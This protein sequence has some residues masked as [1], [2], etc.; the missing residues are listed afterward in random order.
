M[1][2]N[3]VLAGVVIC[4]GSLMSTAANSMFMDVTS[5]VDT[6]D[7]T[8]TGQLGSISVNGSL[9]GSDYVRF[10][11]PTF[12]QNWAYSV[13]NGSS[14]QYSDSSIY[15]PSNPTGDQVGYASYASSNIGILTIAFSEAIT[16]PVF[17]IGNLDSMVYDFSYMGLTVSDLLLLSSNGGADGDGLVLDAVNPVLKDGNPAT[18]VGTPGFDPIPTSGARSGYGSVMLLGTFSTLEIGLYRN[19]SAISGDGGTFQ[20]SLP[21]AVP[22]P[23]TLALFGIGLAGLGFA[24]KK[25]KAH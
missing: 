23:A 21:A 10:T 9:A 24:R 13:I 6:F 17:H 1:S 15:T 12:S 5:V 2:L 25:K 20:I 19:A 7:G 8:F 11:S 22:E 4:A 16:N 14:I 18:L 3:K